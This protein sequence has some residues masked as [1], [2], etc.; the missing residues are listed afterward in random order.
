M[1]PSISNAGLQGLDD[2]QDNLNNVRMTIHHY[3]TKTILK[4]CKG[5]N[6]VIGFQRS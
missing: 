1:A 3:F 2:R 4:R 5:V 6:S